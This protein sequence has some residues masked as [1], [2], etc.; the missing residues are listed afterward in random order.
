VSE[1]LLTGRDAVP[2]PGTWV[3][4]GP[5]RALVLDGD[6][7]NISVGGIEL[8]RRIYLAVRDLDWNTLPGA[9]SGLEIETGAG[10]FS[11]R[12]TVRSTGETPGATIDV[13]TEVE[14]EGSAD[15][16]VSFAM[17]GEALTAF[18]F[19]KIGLCVHHPVRGWAGGAYTGQT[20]IGP[21]SGTLPDEI[22][23]QVHLD[24]GTD[25]PLFE[26][27]SQ[28]TIRHD[29]GGEVSFAFEGELWEMEDQRNWT[30][31]S[32]KSASTPARLGYHHEAAVGRR[33]DQR[34]VITHSGFPVTDAA[35]PGPLGT[36][37]LRPA[38]PL[39]M[40][41]IG[42]GS[43]TAD[44]P[45][46]ASPP[47]TALLATIAPSHLRVDV[48]T[49][50]PTSSCRLADAVALAAE[51]GAGLEVALTIAGA[52]PGPGELDE[53]G[54]AL[55]GLGARLRRVL[56][57]SESEPVT[58]RAT[59]D[60][61]RA[62][63][64]IEAALVTGTNVYF[65][66]INRAREAPGDG[67]GVVWSINPQVH[68]FDDL[69]I[70][71]NLE[72]Q[73]DTVESGRAIAPGSVFHLSPI[74]LRPRFNAVAVTTDPAAPPPPPLSDDRQPSLLAAAW[75]LGSIATLVGAGVAGLTYFETA[76]PRGVVDAS[77]A[78]PAAVV[79]ADA[80]S[81]TG[82]ALRPVD[83][84]DPARVLALGAQASDG[85]TTVLAA[86][87][88]REPQ[89]LRITAS[90]IASAAVRVLD[91]RSWPSPAD[92]EAL[93]EFLAQRTPLTPSADD[94][95]EVTMNAYATIRLDLVR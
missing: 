33:F 72:A 86:N 74:T 4:A 36:A 87:L 19:A 77:G 13:R 27:A 10:G 62:A 23:P 82:R 83:G 95:I 26:P 15:G 12:Y 30:D 73:A 66:Q 46:G 35:A 76:G 79:I 16:T 67:V 22:G 5:V 43:S 42:L 8:V 41:P 52:E 59:I 45:A 85:T 71:E 9:I 32:Y 40:P 90:E 63:S 48:G 39:V 65:N 56:V 57:F 61:V 6:L 58:S 2:D 21:I 80:A 11:V 92:A 24:D 69:S 49:A 38:G 53:L 37:S 81:L 84:L 68:A 93:A 91:E 70:L 31:A 47:V 14:I 17:R 25:E 50:D 51:I 20:P 55:R 7:R 94:T 18:P 1:R 75:T 44:G 60:A 28:L 34:I 29:S 54:T 3:T 89:L 78:F 88:T 64:G